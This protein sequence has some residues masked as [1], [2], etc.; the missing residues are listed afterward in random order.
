MTKIQTSRIQSILSFFI[1]SIATLHGEILDVEKSELKFGFI[2]LIN[3]TLIVIAKEKGFFEDEGLQV[4][5][6]AQ[7]SWKQLLDNVIT[8]ELDGVLM[9]P[10]QPIVAPI[11]FGTKVPIGYLNA[12]SYSFEN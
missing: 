3:C 2:K 4:E 7:P 11:G 1:F 8:R 5:V 12:P 10:G 9:L 6:I